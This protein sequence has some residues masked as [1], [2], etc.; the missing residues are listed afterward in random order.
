MIYLLLTT[1]S[2]TSIYVIFKLAENYSC[3]LPNLISLNY[4]VATIIGFGLLSEFNTNLISDSKSWLTFS[5]ILGVLFIAMFYLI[6]S[7]SQKAGITVTTLANKLS[8]IFPV[9]FSLIYFNE[10]I[11]PIKYIGIITALIAVFLT[12]FKSEIRK[13]NLIF[14]LLPISIF[15]GSGFTDSLVKYVQTI[16]IDQTESAIFSSFVF[17]VAF[18]IS[19]II[20]LFRMKM[21]WKGLHTPT[22]IFGILLGLVNLG[23][24]YFLINALNKSNLRSSLVFT[25]VNISIVL[26]SAITGRL[27]FNEKLSKINM[28]GIFLAIVSI[29]FL[30]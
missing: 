5:I 8:L 3:K 9:M 11:P 17:L 25:V 10:K 29:Y 27:L 2:S 20:L 7:S 18:I 1:V 13:T 24:L 12:L 21:N 23:S 6:G 16:K 22:L 19:L 4:L 26:L 15:L 28:A 14:L 30:L